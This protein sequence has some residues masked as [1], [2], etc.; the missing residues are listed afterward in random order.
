MNTK[1]LL[2]WTSA[3]MTAALLQA[4]AQFGKLTPESE[5]KKA[6]PA[7]ARTPATQAPAAPQ[8][9]GEPAQAGAEGDETEA[10]HVSLPPVEVVQQDAAVLA[11]RDPFWPIGWEPPP[12][13]T[14]PVDVTPKSPIQWEDAK[15]TI[16]VTA[17]SKTV[18]G[19]YVAILKGVGLVEKGDVISISHKGLMYRWTVSD[20]TAL[21]VKTT[22][23]DVAAIRR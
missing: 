15:N 1:N 16:R 12:L 22:Q 11:I 20:V 18:N 21:G 6:A 10:T 9:G 3:G 14:G 7:A 8:P 2:L 4:H 13:N 5:T 17:L 23:L 19:D